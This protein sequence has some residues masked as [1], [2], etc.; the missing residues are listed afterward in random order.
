MVMGGIVRTLGWV[1]APVALAGG[2]GARAQ[3]TPAAEAQVPPADAAAQTP[4]TTDAPAVAAAQPAAT[5]EPTSTGRRTSYPASYFTQYAPSTA[6]QIVQ[7]V[8]G[9]TIQETDQNVR[10]FAGAAGNVVINGQRPSSKTDSLETI[11]A[12][13]PANRVLRVEVGP[14]ELYGAEYAGKPQVLNLVTN[15][16]GGVAGTMTAAVSRDFTGKLRP[17]GSVSALVRSGKSTFNLA[18]TISQSR[19]ADEGTDTITSLPSGALIERREKVNHYREPNAAATAS[20]DYNGGTNNTAHLNLRYAADRLDLTQVN[21]VFPVAGAARDDRLFQRY[22]EDDYEIG[23]DVTQPFAGGGLKLIGLATRTNR[24]NRDLSLVRSPGG[25]TQGG[26]A[27]NLNDRLDERV[28]RT[29]W[30]RPDLAGWAVEAGGELAIN[31]LRSRVDLFSLG[32]GGV[33]TRIDLP[34]DDAKVEERRGEAFVNAGKALSKALRL[35]LG[36]T[37]ERSNL[38]V[39][40]DATAARTLQFWKPKATLDWRPVDSKW[41]VQAS[42]QRTVAQLQFTDFI[43]SAELS[44]ERVNGGNP[45]LLPQRAWESLLTIERPILGDGSAR[46]ELG[47]NRISLVQDRVPT[48]DGFDAP[49]NLGSGSVLIVRPRVDAP[50]GGLGIKGGRLTVYVSY[51]RSRVEDPYTLTQRRF[52]GSSDLFTQ[53]DFR[54]DLGKFAWGA[55]LSGGSDFA[56][57][58]L[59]EVDHFHNRY[60]QTNAFVEYRPDAKTT[61]TLEA[62]NLTQSRQTRDRRFYAPNRANP[63][64]FQREV[65]ERNLHIVPQ[66]TIKRAFG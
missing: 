56:Y 13:I 20:W 15:A 24:D 3:T 30:N 18:G 51:V 54:Q 27:Q 1:A 39:S 33:P 60:P 43:S 17:S 5:S 47:Y 49:G 64:P 41:H 37:Y 42:V 7:R 2:V 8:P 4:R 38:T 32:A 9:F 28:V 34:V 10:G 48:P 46:L 61:I 40:G 65:R 44:N 63:N 29:V 25:V 55:T 45:D 6:F 58:R 19:T 35:D 53:V 16:A 57:Y 66:L 26:F 12:R 50:L 31:T 11:L 23:G 22:Y 52:S 21:H 14:G 59:N 36:L 62:R